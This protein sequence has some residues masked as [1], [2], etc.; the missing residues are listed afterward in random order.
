MA[1][2]SPAFP[3]PPSPSLLSPK[4]NR[5]FPPRSLPL[6]SPFSAL[7][8]PPEAGE[9]ACIHHAFI[10]PFLQ[11]GTVPRSLLG[12]NLP[13]LCPSPLPLS[14]LLNG[15]EEETISLPIPHRICS[16]ASCLAVWGRS[17]GLE[18][19]KPPPAS[20]PDLATPKLQSLTVHGPLGS[21]QRSP[22]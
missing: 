16:R 1:I 6:I 10:I 4:A 9:K 15:A 14:T 20:S 3:S 2:G 5:P 17:H 7:S 11:A 18:R 19:N 12:R 21:V 13:S 8:F 22:D